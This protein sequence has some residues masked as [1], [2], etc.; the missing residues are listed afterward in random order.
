MED[1][2][3]KE[4]IPLLASCE[5]NQSC[6]TVLERLGGLGANGTAEGILQQ[7]LLRIKYWSH[8]AWH[9]PSLNEQRKQ[10][11]R[12]QLYSTESLTGEG[13]YFC[14]YQ[15]SGK[16]EQYLKE[17]QRIGFNLMFLFT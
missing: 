12:S 1:I 6:R 11:I 3:W 16:Y 17:L 4:M 10:Y 8:T 7:N 5:E 2:N 15:L 13:H 9:D 14:Y